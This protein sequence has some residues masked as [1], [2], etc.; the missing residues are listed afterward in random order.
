MTGKKEQAKPRKGKAKTFEQL[1]ALFVSSQKRAKEYASQCAEMALKHFEKHGDLSYCQKFH[2]A[3]DEKF[4][5]RVVFLAWLRAYS[6]ITIEKG[7]LKKDGSPDAPEFN[8]E[9]AC[10]RPYWEHDLVPK[11]QIYFGGDDVVTQIN[12]VVSRF[13]S[14][15]YVAKDEAAIAKVNE[16]KRRMANL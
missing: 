11:E 7:Q 4:G 14:E 1:L 2:D 3:I 15:R 12:R 13:E 9:K 6:P 5:R 10:S 16:V 8:V